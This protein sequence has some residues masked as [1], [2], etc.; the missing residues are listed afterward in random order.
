MSTRIVPAPEPPVTRVSSGPREEF[1][2]NASANADQRS[3]TSS[4]AERKTEQ[5]SGAAPT[6]ASGAANL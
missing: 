4:Q 2:L 1:L 6:I 5:Q 3:R